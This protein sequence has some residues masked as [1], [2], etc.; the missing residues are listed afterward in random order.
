MAVQL[1]CVTKYLSELDFVMWDVRSDDIL[2]DEGPGR[3]T[4][5]VTMLD[6]FMLPSEILG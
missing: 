6:V 5:R 2:I 4:A 1:A 3:Q